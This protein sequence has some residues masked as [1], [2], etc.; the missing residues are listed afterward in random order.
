MPSLRDQ[1]KNLQAPVSRS[2]GV[3]RERASLLFDRKEAASFSTEEFYNLGLSGLEQLRKLDRSLVDYEEKLFGPSSIALNRAMLSKD[4][5][6]EL[7]ESLERMIIYLSPYFNH[8]GCKQVLEWLIHKYHI[9]LYNGPFIANAFFVYHST[10]S[11]G[12]LL[13]I[14]KID[15]PEWEFTKEF[16]KEALPNSVHCNFEIVFE[17]RCKS[18]LVGFLFGIPCSTLFSRLEMTT[19]VVHL[20]EDTAN[21]TEQLISRV[22]PFVG[23]ALKSK[24]LPFKMSGFMIVCDLVMN[25]SLNED[26][27]TNILK[28]T[29]LKMH[30]EWFEVA[31]NVV[32]VICQRQNIK[33]LPKKAFVKLLRK[34][35]SLNL[36]NY[37]IDAHSN[38]D[39][40]GFVLPFVNTAFECIAEEEDIEQKKLIASYITVVLNLDAMNESQAAA[41]IHACL[42]FL[43]TSESAQVPEELRLLLKQIVLRFVPTFD[44]IRAEMMITNKE[45]LTRFLEQCEIAD[46]EIGMLDFGDKKK[47]RRRSS[48]SRN[49]DEEPIDEAEPVQQPS[50]KATKKLKT[51]DQLKNLQEG[52][53][54]QKSF[55]KPPSAVLEM[56][57]NDE[58]FE[59][60]EWALQTLESDKYLAKQLPDHLE[61]FLLAIVRF[62]SKNPKSQY[63]SLLRQ[64]LLKIKISDKL[65]LPL[66][67]PYEQETETKRGRFAKAAHNPMSIFAE[68]TDA[69][70]EARLSFVLDLFNESSAFKATTALVNQLFDLVGIS[71]KPPKAYSAIKKKLHIQQM[72][73]ILICKLLKEQGAK[74]LLSEQ[75]HL[76]SLVNAI[77]FTHDTV[78][79]RNALKVLTCVAPLIPIQLTT[80]IMSLFTFMGSGLLKKDNELTLM[81]VEEAFRALFSAILT[82]NQTQPAT[83]KRRLLEISQIFAKSLIDIPAHRRARIL[84]TLASCVLPESLWIIF[85]AIFDAIC[86]QWKKDS[87]DKQDDNLSTVCLEF[88]GTLEP[89]KQIQL[90]LD[91]LEYVV[92]LGGDSEQQIDGLADNKRFLMIFDRKTQPHLKLRHF[93]YMIVGFVWQILKQPVFCSQLAELP[94]NNAI[95]ERMSVIGNRLIEV[96]ALIEDFAS[97]ELSAAERNENK[98]RGT[99][100][101]ATQLKT[102]RYWAALN[103]RTKNIIAKVCGSFSVDVRQRIVLKLVNDTDML[104]YLPK[105]TRELAEQEAKSFEDKLNDVIE[106]MNESLKIP[107]KLTELSSSLEVLLASEDAAEQIDELAKQIFPVFYELFNVRM[108]SY[109]DSTPDDI[110]SS[111]QAI[112]KAFISL[113]ENLSEEDLTPVFSQMSDWVSEAL[114]A[115]SKVRN[116]HR[117]LTVYNFANK[118]YEHFN[119]LALSY[120]SQ[121]FVYTPKIL[122]QMNA[123]KTDTEELFIDGTDKQNANDQIAN[124][125][126]TAIIDF[127]NNC[128]KHSF[129]MGDDRAELVYEAVLDEIENRKIH[130][131]KQRC[132]EHLVDCIYHLSES[133][134][135]LFMNS[136]CQ[137]LLDKMHDSNSRV[138]LQALLIFEKLVARIGDALAPLLPT[139]VQY[140]SELLEDSDTKISEQCDA[141]ISQLKL[142]FGEDI[143]NDR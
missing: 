11:F 131:Y 117:V 44:A 116:R 134:P 72:T 97:N 38:F 79:L 141:T 62:A 56:M 47:R 132:N 81:I 54:V 94:D 55:K 103:K 12:R 76:D 45:V 46:Y 58:V 73:L 105:L 53:N 106:K 59:K 119:N 17:R 48:Q 30:A 80:Q 66:I 89:E 5:N 28:L 114:E 33:L 1:L 77:Q 9:H 86:T 14:L 8:Q 71:D 24:V 39:L 13:K 41:A 127:I 65:Q 96:L 27:L 18:F 143:L 102:L 112:S 32:M 51:E 84:K 36:S 31:M 3:E 2:L 78:V 49:Y 61:D 110:F 142:V 136:L 43:L 140:L 10:N 121:L 129:F 120:F 74:A 42:N 100:E 23:A 64:S 87:N 135:D 67:L 7:D 20:F 6:E 111:E 126:I 75:I 63:K 37:I 40:T 29:M 21:I 85:G 101:S 124:Q 90:A 95:Y 113:A 137:K 34:G 130:G 123:A 115:G 22:I 107:N 122:K 88:I 70:F 109:K 138:R 139:V 99:T 91:I 118:F 15:R 108:R 133:A 35:D 4:E 16:S 69:E 57:N 92:H 104:S 26:V 82:A 128:A 19:I 83:Y 125:L 98:A 60:V 50:V 93:R 52:G 68:E 25:T